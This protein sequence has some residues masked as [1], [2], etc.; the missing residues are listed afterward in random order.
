MTETL[1]VA[2]AEIEKLPASDQ[3]HI[4][5]QMLAH[6]KKLRILRED[7]D[8]GIAELDAGEGAELDINDVLS[9][10]HEEGGAR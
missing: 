4:G 6:V 2:V 5:R 8:E 7:I 3:E 10:A 9:A 1:E